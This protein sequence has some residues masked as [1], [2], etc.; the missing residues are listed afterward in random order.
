MGH[1]GE[2]TMSEANKAFDVV[3]LLRDARDGS[4]DAWA[5]LMLRL[6]SSHE[7]QRLQGA[8]SKPMLLS[9]ALYRKATDSVMSEMLANLNMPSREEVLALS[10]RL[11]RI[12]MVLDDLGANLD[13]LRRMV[14]ASRSRTTPRERDVPS[15]NRP[16]SAKEA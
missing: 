1:P 14:V 9:I 8:I 11:T 5:K 10:Q 15:E 7:Y 12:E 13:Q 2:P 16:V 4:M 3:K 6:T